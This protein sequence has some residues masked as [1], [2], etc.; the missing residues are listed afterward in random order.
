[1]P[2]RAMRAVSAPSQGPP[3]RA[4]AARS[5]RFARFRW[6]APPSFLP[7]TNITRPLGPRDSGVALVNTR[8]R[9]LVPRL[10]SAKSLSMS[11]A[12]V[13]VRM[14]AP[15]D[16]PRTGLRRAR[17]ENL[18]ALP[19]ACCND[20]SATTGRHA[21]AEAVRL[22]A[23]PVVRL[24]CA[25]HVNILR[26]GTPRTGPDVKP[27]DYTDHPRR[28]SNLTLV[29]L[30]ARSRGFQVGERR[31]HRPSAK[32]VRKLWIV[33]KTHDSR[34]W[35]LWI[36]SVLALLEQR[37]SGRIGAVLR[38]RSISL[39]DLEN[40]LIAG[41]YMERGGPRPNRCP[42]F[43]QPLPSTRTTQIVLS[44]ETSRVAAG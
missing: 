39:S 22:G 38:K 33:W 12:A 27:G 13:I 6:T 40:A 9:G 5:T 31:F 42:V 25:L 35:R 3:R 37:P 26:P 15:D 21:N 43:P 30:P 29:R 32:K 16:R 7:A 28:V 1:M 11:A 23:L 36:T 14:G 8:T 41:L 34:L 18:A 4:Q 2:W 17:G 19:P 44:T 10:P 20:R 24:I